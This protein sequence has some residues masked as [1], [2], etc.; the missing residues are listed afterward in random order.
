MI[1]LFNKLITAG[2]KLIYL[3]AVN[4]RVYPEYGICVQIK[5]DKFLF[6]PTDNRRSKWLN[7]KSILLRL[8]PDKEQ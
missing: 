1:D 8:N 2:D 4:S 3:G 7:C 6:K 5:D